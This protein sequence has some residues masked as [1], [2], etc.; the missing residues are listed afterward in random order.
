MPPG[1]RS[2]AALCFY[3]PKRGTDRLYG[4]CRNLQFANQPL[5][6][7]GM[8]DWWTGRRSAHVTRR[9]ATKHHKTA[10]RMPTTATGNKWWTTKYGEA[11]RIVQLLL[12]LV[13]TFSAWRYC[14]DEKRAGFTTR[15]LFLGLPIHSGA[16]RLDGS[17]I[18]CDQSSHLQHPVLDPGNLFHAIFGSPRSCLDLWAAFCARL[19][20]GTSII[21]FACSCRIYVHRELLSLLSTLSGLFGHRHW[22]E[23]F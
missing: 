5:H 16:R 15:R 10:S 13:R 19:C 3:T 6:G 22:R 7:T 23:V 2:A 1:S 11:F 14:L 9:A 17:E 18:W 20:P 21:I 12:H 4:L 8:H